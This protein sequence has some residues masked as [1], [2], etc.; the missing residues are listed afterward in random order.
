VSAYKTEGLK[1]LKD[2]TRG[3]KSEDK[4]FLNK[5]IGKKIQEMITDTMP[6]QLKLHYALWT[7][8]AVKELVVREFGIILAISRHTMG[9]YLRSWGFSTQKP[10]KRAYEQYS[11]SFNCDWTRSIRLLRNE[12][13]KEGAVIHWDDGTVVRNSNQH[14]LSHAPKGKD[15]CKTKYVKTFLCEYD[16]YCNQSRD[17]GIYDLLKKYECREINSVFD[18]TQK[19][20]PRKVF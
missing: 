17:C 19:N 10:K 18:A 1:G 4:M 16:F 8:K 6:D 13:K 5:K 11:K 20:K 14:G 2:Q 3:V 12:Q 7:Q 9:D 15:I